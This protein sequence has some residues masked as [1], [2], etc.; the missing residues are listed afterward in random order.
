M[1]RNSHRQAWYL[2]RHLKHL[3]NSLAAAGF[4]EAALLVGAA[5]MSV[6]DQVAEHGKRPDE[7]SSVVTM[8]S[9]R[10]SSTQ[11]G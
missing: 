2:A 6:G 3:S 7:T 11:H 9:S 4:S 5:A 10:Q 8:I 1:Q